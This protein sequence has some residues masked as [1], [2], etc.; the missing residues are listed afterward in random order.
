MKDHKAR[1]KIGEEY[2]SISANLIDFL[3]LNDQAKKFGL[4]SFDLKLYLLVQINGKTEDYSIST[5]QQL[6]LELPLL[7]DSDGENELNGK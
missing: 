1:I 6:D 4:G 7:L 2:R 3:S 5:Q